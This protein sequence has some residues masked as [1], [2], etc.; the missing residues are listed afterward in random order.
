VKNRIKAA[1]ISVS[2]SGNRIRV[3]PALF[4]NEGDIDKLIETLNA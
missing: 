1:S 4:N 2:G 3:S